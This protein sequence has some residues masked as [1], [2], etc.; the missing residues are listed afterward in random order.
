MGP[1]NGRGRRSLAKQHHVQERERMQH[2]KH[3]ENDSW[4]EEAQGTNT[5]KEVTGLRLFSRYEV[6]VTAFNSK[7]ESPHSP[8]HHFNTPEG[9]EFKVK[10]EFYRIKWPI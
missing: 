6:S 10:T 8:H 9:G 1:Q 2:V 4:V 7:G 5:S 3:R